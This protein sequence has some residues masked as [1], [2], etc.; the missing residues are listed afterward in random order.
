MAT[1]KLTEGIQHKLLVKLLE[2]DY[3]I[4][5]KKGK[6]NVVANALSRRDVPDHSHYQTMTQVIPSWVEE[7]NSAIW[8]M[9]IANNSYRR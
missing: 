8:E 1:Q 4:E 5:Y 7:V 3:E 2:F 9:L 6:E